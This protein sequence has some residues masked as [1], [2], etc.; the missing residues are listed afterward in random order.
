M[1]SLKQVILPA[2]KLSFTFV[3]HTLQGFFLSF[4][5][6]DC[7]IRPKKRRLF[8]KVR[9][10]LSL[11]IHLLYLSVNIIST[12]STSLANNTLALMLTTCSLSIFICRCD[13]GQDPVPSLI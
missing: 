8:H 7:R 9:H 5:S 13:F 11:S 1:G 12:S 2:V 4:N 3:S 10:V 6:E